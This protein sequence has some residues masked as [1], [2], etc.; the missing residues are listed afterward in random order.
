MR[1]RGKAKMSVPSKLTR[2]DVGV[3]QCH[4]QP[5]KCRLTTTGLTYEPERF[6]APNRKAYFGDGVVGPEPTLQQPPGGDREFLADAHEL[7]DGFP[8][9]I[10][11]DVAISHRRCFILRPAMV[12]RAATDHTGGPDHARPHPPSGDADPTGA[13]HP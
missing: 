3:F 13:R 6:A 12:V 1:S 2:P 10:S 11:L 4:R 7:E 8:S 9:A 5:T